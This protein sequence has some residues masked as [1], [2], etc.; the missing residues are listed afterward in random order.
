MPIEVNFA[1]VRFVKFV[2]LS[3]LYFARDRLLIDAQNLLSF[4]GRDFFSNPTDGNN[5]AFHLI[6]LCFVTGTG[7]LNEWSQSE[8]VEID[9]CAARQR[10]VGESVLLEFCNLCKF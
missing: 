3:L 10:S 7:A 4:R 5:P 2:Y 6:P 8:T 1:I 9:L